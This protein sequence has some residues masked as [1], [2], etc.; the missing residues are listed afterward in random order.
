VEPIK[1]LEEQ[2]ARIWKI[3]DVSHKE[4]G[5]F[6]TLS[7]Q[8]VTDS[9]ATSQQGPGLQPPHEKPKPIIGHSKEVGR[10]D[11]CPCG[12]GKKYKKCCGSR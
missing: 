7:Q 6:E 3:S 5:S 10:N 1:E 4:L 8:P 2:L 9:G 11:P 12:S